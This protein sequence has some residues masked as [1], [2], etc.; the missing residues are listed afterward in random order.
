MCGRFTLR[1]PTKDIAEV[2]DLLHA[3]ELAP[4]YNIAPSQPVAAVRLAE[5]H[6]ELS[7]LHWGLIPFWAKDPKVGS[8]TV[9]ARAESVATKPAFRQAFAKRRRVIVADVFY[10]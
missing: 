3:F 6:R 1:T 9:N 2:F 8:S 10:E 4:R 7:M 5:G